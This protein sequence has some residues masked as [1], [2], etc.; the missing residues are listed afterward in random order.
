V[1]SQ[2][3]AGLDRR[4]E[5]SAE[6]QC[7]QGAADAGRAPRRLRARRPHGAG[8][9]PTRTSY[10]I[11]TPAMLYYLNGVSSAVHEALVQ[12]LGMNPD[13]SSCLISTNRRDD[14]QSRLPRRPALRRL[15]RRHHHRGS[16]QR[17]PGQTALLQDTLVDLLQKDPGVRGEDVFVMIH[18]TPPANFSFASGCP[19]RLS[20]RSRRRSPTV[21]RFSG[22]TNS[23]AS[24]GASMT[25]TATGPR[26]APNSPSTASSMP[27]LP[28]GAD[29]G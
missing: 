10:P 8:F 7:K 26:S 22:R 11:S 16:R 5:V 6:C 17:Q 19:K 18:L 1:P 25:A 21:G 24:S 15:H 23:T 4:L 2:S 12:E 29:P 14:L 20:S 28:R 13:V 9:A 3:N 27:A